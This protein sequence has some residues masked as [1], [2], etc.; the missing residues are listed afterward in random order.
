MRK[1]AKSQSVQQRQSDLLMTFSGKDHKAIA[2]LL[3][4][5]LKENKQES[6]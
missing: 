1:H 3:K 2:L 5:W 6:D 4:K